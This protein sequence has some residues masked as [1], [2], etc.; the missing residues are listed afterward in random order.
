MICQP[1]RRRSSRRPSRPTRHQP[2]R[3]H[4]S[5]CC[6]RRHRRR[7]LYPHRCRHR[8]LQ[9][10]RRRRLRPRRSGRI[11]STYTRSGEPLA[12][13]RTAAHTNSHEHPIIH[14]PAWT[15]PSASHPCAT[16]TIHLFALRASAHTHRHPVFLCLPPQLASS[17]E[18]HCERVRR[19]G[20]QAN[21]RAGAGGTARRVESRRTPRPLRPSACARPRHSR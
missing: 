11:S 8:L 17:R 4:R 2:R 20:V 13:L 18:W 5:P 14:A 1:S 6:L 3:H 21:A 7:R 12:A 15:P 9:I 16:H 19:G 10:R